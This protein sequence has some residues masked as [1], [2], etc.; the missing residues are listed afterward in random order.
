MSLT[1]HQ[2]DAIIYPEDNGEPLAEN[3]LQYEYIVMVKEGLESLFSRRDDVFIA[4]DLLWY[5]VEGR[6]RVRIAPDVMVVFGRP[7]GYRGSY[8]QWQ[9]GDL[10]PQ[11]VFEI[12][13]PGN[14]GPE[15]LAKLAF[16]NQ[17]GV[18]EYFEYDPLTGT[19]SGWQRL[20]TTGD[21]LPVEAM[22]G[23][24][25]P[26]LGVRF[27]LDDQRLVLYRPDGEPFKSLVQMTEERNAANQRAEREEERANQAEA[28]ATE[29]AAAAERLREKLRALGIDPDAA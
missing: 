1:L 29:A 9:E 15:M 14:T 16:Y 27:D 17:H 3:T 22:R 23:W 28:R 10:P 26:R 11:V 8:L 19:L 21:L 6:N 13:S 20:D 7:K 4:A 24:T 12:L 5:P 25:S 2:P 18:E